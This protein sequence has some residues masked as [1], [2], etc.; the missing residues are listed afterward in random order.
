VVLEKY[1]VTEEYCDPF[2]LV[3][4]DTVWIHPD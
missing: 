4:K 1:H 3:L 2:Y